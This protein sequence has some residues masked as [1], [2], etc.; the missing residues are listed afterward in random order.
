[1]HELLFW[2][3]GGDFDPQTFPT[4]VDVL[5]ERCDR[6]IVR[7]TI[8]NLTQFRSSAIRLQLLNGVCRTRSR[9]PVYRLLSQE[10]TQ[11]IDSIGRIF[12]DLKADLSKGDGLEPAQYCVLSDCR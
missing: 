9:R 1:M 5:S 4:L 11:R 8:A 10:D 7:P 3:F 12:R 2:H 6:R